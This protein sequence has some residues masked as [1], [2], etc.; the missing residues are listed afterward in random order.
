VIHAGQTP[1]VGQQID[2]SQEPGPVPSPAPQHVDPHAERRAE[3]VRELFE[4]KMSIAV[5]ATPI[6]D[7]I[8]QIRPH[9][10]APIVVRSSDD[11]IG[12][13]IDADARVTAFYQNI[14]PVM[15]LEDI[16]LQVSHPDDPCTWQMRRGFVEVG[17]KSRLSVPAACERRMYYIRD[18]MLNES[19]DMTGGEARVPADAMALDLVELIV[20]TIEPEMWDWGQVDYEIVGPPAPPSAVEP[21]SSVP[22]DD[23]TLQRRINPRENPAANPAN[24]PDPRYIP[25]QKPAIIRH[26][27]DVIIVD[28]PDFVHRQIAGYAQGQSE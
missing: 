4:A 21:G 10:S 3:I 1:A 8:E 24:A 2:A 9:L 22:I 11:P 16:L 19:L 20:T 12:Y 18:M 5:T 27:R 26:W 13:G 14:A 23:G 6:L 25:R 17:P 7:V 28:A 15:V